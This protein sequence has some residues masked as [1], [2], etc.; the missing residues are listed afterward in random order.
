M[1]K[2]LDIPLLYPY[3]P[4]I[5]KRNIYITQEVFESMKAQ[6]AKENRSISN[7]LCW[8]HDTYLHY[9]SKENTGKTLVESLGEVGLLDGEVELNL[10]RESNGANDCDGGKEGGASL[11]AE[12]VGKDIER[13]AEKIRE[14]LK[15]DLDN[16]VMK[17]SFRPYSKETQLKKGKKE[18]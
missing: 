14:G 6:A 16:I 4:H 2:S 8:L 3:N 17:K 13:R 5:M 9:T 7:Y 10:G 18:R 15:Q 12:I 1:E 11:E